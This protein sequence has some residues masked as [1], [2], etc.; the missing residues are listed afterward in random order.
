MINIDVDYLDMKLI[1][2]S[3]DFLVA[4]CINQMQYLALMQMVAQLTGV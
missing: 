1:Q 2:R 4:G 3:S